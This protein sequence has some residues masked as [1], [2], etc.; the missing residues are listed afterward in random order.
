[1]MCGLTNRILIM[2]NIQKNRFSIATKEPYNINNV[3][4]KQDEFFD[5]VQVEQMIKK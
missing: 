1:M 3:W 2:M 4:I 5:N